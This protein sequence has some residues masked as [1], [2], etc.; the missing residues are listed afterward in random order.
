MIKEQA[1]QRTVTVTLEPV[2][3]CRC[4]TSFGIS[5]TLYSHLKNNHNYFYCPNGHSQHFISETEEEKLKRQLQWQKEHN[6]WLSKANKKKEAQIRGLK[7]SVTKI[8]KRVGKGACPCCNRHFVNLERHMSCK[9]PD[10]S[11]EKK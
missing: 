11:E 9:H 10:Y 8:K 3:C 6:E 2:T 4:G 7:G 1:Y 5:S